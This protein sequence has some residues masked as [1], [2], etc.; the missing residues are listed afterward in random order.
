M[1][2]TELNVVM[3]MDDTNG[4]K[5]LS[6]AL[7]GMGIYA[8]FYRELD[9]F[10]VGVQ[11]ETPDLAI[12]DVTKMS[13]GLTQFKNHPLVAGNKLHYA[14]YSSE[15]TKPLL[16][17]TLNLNPIAYLNSDITL[18]K[19]IESIVNILKS[20]KTLKTTLKEQRVRLE[21]TH[22]K[23]QRLLIE[24][25]D[26]MEFKSYFDFIYN[27]SREIAD[28]SV[29]TDFNLALCHY[30][31][32]WNQ[33]KLFSVC[34]LSN[35]TQKLI[36]PV[37][38]KDKYVEMP[39][40]F[41]GQSNPNGL[42]DLPRQMSMQVARDLMDQPI[43]LKITGEKKFPE[44]LI[45][46]ELGESVGNFPWVILEE[47]LSS[48]YRSQKLLKISPKIEHQMIPTW[49]ALDLMDKMH[50]HQ[51]ENSERIVCVNFY[52]LIN[53]TKNRI[54]EKFYWTAMFN[55][56]FMKITQV[57]HL[58]VKMSFFGPWQLVLF[59][60]DTFVESEV[61]KLEWLLKDFP[62]WKYFENDARAMA[63]SVKPNLKVLTPSSINYLRAHL[64]ECENLT[65][66]MPTGKM[67]SP[68]RIGRNEIRHNA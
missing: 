65:N 46:V 62:F 51:L 59:I 1:K 12:V 36:S 34:E 9:A 28:M 35:N 42:E 41:L 50:S 5:E 23:T 7:R 24:K 18:G 21:M 31:S 54:G 57:M 67:I 39:S 20:E 52:T 27:F 53:E 66:T 10:W 17:S 32:E 29:R 11:T 64:K 45:F 63:L 4:A 3:L 40:V 25:Q 44:M 60:P 37:S 19:Q 30:F 33:V 2:E 61:E 15:E 38:Y 68:S 55:D 58:S 22:N 43:M 56:F 26:A 8:N 6:L 47:R 13:F 14:F 48:I 16:Q 49:T